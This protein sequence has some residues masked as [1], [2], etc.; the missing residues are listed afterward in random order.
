MAKREILFPVRRLRALRTICGSWS[1]RKGTLA[2]PANLAVMESHSSYFFGSY[3]PNQGTQINSVP[4]AA[5][6]R[7]GE[8]GAKVAV[9]WGVGLGATTHAGSVG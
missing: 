1:K 9:G 7:R 3:A 2:A 8:R 4:F 6:A 5:N